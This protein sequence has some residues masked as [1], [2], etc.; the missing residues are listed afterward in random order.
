MKLNSSHPLTQ[1][2]EY[3]TADKSL[4]LVKKIPQ[5]NRRVGVNWSIRINSYKHSY[6][7]ECIQQSPCQS[8]HQGLQS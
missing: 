6:T 5:T 2:P 3:A 1:G 7:V 4:Y 8:L